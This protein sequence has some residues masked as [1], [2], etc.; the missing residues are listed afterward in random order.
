MKVI[1]TEQREKGRVRRMT[2]GKI[3]ERN[4]GTEKKGE[5]ARGREDKGKRSSREEGMNGRERER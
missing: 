2:M 4:E 3:R 5:R 1:D